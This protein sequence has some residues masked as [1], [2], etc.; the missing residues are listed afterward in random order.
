[1]VHWFQCECGAKRGRMSAEPVTCRCGREMQ[2]DRSRKKLEFGAPRLSSAFNGKI[3]EASGMH[4]SQIPEARA[5]IAKYGMHGVE[6][7][8]K[9]EEHPHTGCMKFSD[10]AARKRWHQAMGIF[11]KNGG[12]GDAAPTGNK[13]PHRGAFAELRDRS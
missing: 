2:R 13:Q 11:D 10:R 8:D 3:E 4:P 12:Y 9:G 5:L 7:L 1:M 6:V